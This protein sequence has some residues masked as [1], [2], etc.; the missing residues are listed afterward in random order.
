MFEI[1]THFKTA[2]GSTLVDVTTVGL[3]PKPKL[4]AE[5]SRRT[6]VHII[7]GTGYYTASSYPASVS[8]LSVEALADEMRRDLLEGLA[9]GEIRAG[10]LGELGVSSQPMPI[11]LRVLRLPAAS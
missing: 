2:G 10:I 7:A 9:G 1:V 11:E 6:G 3:A 4:L 5:V 8:E